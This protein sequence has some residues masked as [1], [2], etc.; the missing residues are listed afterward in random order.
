MFCV[1]STKNYSIVLCI[2]CVIRFQMFVLHIYFYESWQVMN[3]NFR[4]GGGRIQS[5]FG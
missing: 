1:S 3:I 2:A 5:G 4:G